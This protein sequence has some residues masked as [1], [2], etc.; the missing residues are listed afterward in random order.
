MLII[1]IIGLLILK[2]KDIENL[3]K[4][5]RKIYI[6]FYEYKNLIEEEAS[7]ILN[8]KKEDINIRY[9]DI[10]YQEDIQEINYY[11]IKII[12]LGL[13]YNGPYSLLE[14]KKFYY[15]QI[16]NMQT[17]NINTNQNNYYS[18]DNNQSNNDKNYNNT[19][20]QS[21]NIN[22]INIELDQLNNNSIH[23]TFYITTPIYYANSN[24]HIGHAYTTVIA[25]VIS[26]FNKLIGKDVKFLTGSDEHGEKIQKASEAKNITPQKLV[27]DLALN[28]KDL[29]AKL[30]IEYNIFSRTS[31][32]AHKN[33]VIEAWNK[34]IEK[35]LIYKG[36]YSGWYS[37]TD[38]TFYDES[39]LTEDGKA[40]TGATVNFISEPTYFFRLSN[41]TDI[42]LKFY[43]DNPNFIYPKNKLKEIVNFVKG[44]LKDLSISRCKK[45]FTWGIP[46]PG[47][48]SH[49][50]YVWLDAL[51]NYA[52]GLNLN[53]KDVQN[54][55]FWPIDLHIVGKDILK[56][57][58]IYWPAFL[59]GLELSFPK[60]IISHGWWLNNS[61]KMSKSIGNV[62]DPNELIEQFS[63]DSLRYF[64]I[65]ELSFNSDGDFTMQKM[66]DRHNK[67]LGNKL[68]NLI[69]R[70]YVFA[71][72]NFDSKVPNLAD[73]TLIYQQEIMQK[74]LLLKEN[75]AN[76]MSQNMLHNSLESIFNFLDDANTYMEENAPWKDKTNESAKIT[77]YTLLEIFRYIAI[78]LY[79]FIPNTSSQILYMLKV[80][81]NERLNLKSLTSANMLSSNIILNE[82]SILFK[83]I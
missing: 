44:G 45:N 81:I 75:F 16:K 15:I 39:E 71:K 80:D 52:S 11:I 21:N 7:K 53:L 26:R 77:I 61:Q 5:I 67:E 73:Y 36:E 76:S 40:P 22:K 74:L 54:S 49:V 1:I 51:L 82:I 27:D 6:I 8:F 29:F 41:Y 66:L 25:D 43:E 58:A 64:M 46:V 14:I 20:N 13:Q 63:C 42:L 59:H 56:F 50:I 72:N 31:L 83:K 23:N 30:N 55:N 37:I 65:R 62:I 48:E 10:L 60:Q 69:Q 57:H 4:I 78:L 28:F 79:P 35:D 3:I 34:L 2:E 24:L 17:N 18:K 68:G 12:E 33:L 38:E 32:I 19:Q 70:V 9:S 47:D